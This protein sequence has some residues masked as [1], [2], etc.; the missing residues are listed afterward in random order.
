MKPMMIP[1]LPLGGVL[2][3]VVD[4]HV[5]NLRRKIDAPFDPVFRGAGGCRYVRGG[6]RSRSASMR[7]R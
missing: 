2:S 6:A 3:N 1:G 5:A 4:V 7:R